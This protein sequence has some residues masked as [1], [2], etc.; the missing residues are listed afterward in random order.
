MSDSKKFSQELV[1]NFNNL[2]ARSELS[3]QIIKDVC[4]FLKKRAEI[5]AE[6]AKKLNQHYK[7]LPGAGVFVKEPP[8]VKET[9]TLKDALQGISDKGIQVSDQHL[10]VSN[11]IMND[12]C[13]V[14]DTWM[15]TKDP[16]RKKIIGEGQKLLKSLADAK[17]NVQKNR[18]NYEKLW[19]DSDIAKDGLLKSEKDQVNQPENKKLEAITKKASENYNSALT[20]AKAS[21]SAYRT[22]V[23]KTNEELNSF[24]T[25]K[26]PALLEQFQQLEQDRWNTLLGIVKSF[27]S[28]QESLPTVIQKEVDELQTV[29]DSA[30]FENDIAELITS[31]K[32]EKDEDKLEF[33][34][35]KSKH[36][37]ETSYSTTSITPSISATAST[38]T[39]TST[40]TSTNKSETPNPLNSTFSTQTAEDRLEQ[41]E[42]SKVPEKSEKEIEEENAAKKKKEEENKKKAEA[43]KANLFGGE[44]DE[45]GMFD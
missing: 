26:M 24:S 38:S 42:K 9:K 34:A 15:K 4:E 39:S 5:E 3:F 30:N 41:Q 33:V 12:I 45:T 25:D 10:E 43:V 40:T 29:I 19:K 17:S 31:A 8:F 28:I 37:P 6:Y 18:A 27:K 2:V 44:E 1:Y 21:D 35:F 7:T 22:S 11:K 13:K 16:E 36:E 23:D 32:K 14:L 20:K